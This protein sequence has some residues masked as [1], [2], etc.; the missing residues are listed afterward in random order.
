MFPKIPAKMV[1][2]DDTVWYSLIEKAWNLLKYRYHML[3]TFS[4][5]F[6]LHEL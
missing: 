3:T 5:G 2:T 1:V 4:A 6:F